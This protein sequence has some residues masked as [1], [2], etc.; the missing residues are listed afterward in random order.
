MVYISRCHVDK[1]WNLC[2]RNA[3]KLGFFYLSMPI[4]TI[5]YLF[6][7]EKQIL[8]R[9]TLTF[10]LYLRRQ[11]NWNRKSTPEISGV[12]GTIFR[13]E[14]FSKKLLNIKGNSSSYGF[15]IQEL[16]FEEANETIIFIIP[17]SFLFNLFL[18]H[19]DSV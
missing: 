12:F 14:E 15:A 11:A 1:K 9:P 10:L 2:K 8:I 4:L 16:S 17:L 19:K 5:N 13:L 18:F 7:S 3:K 6:T